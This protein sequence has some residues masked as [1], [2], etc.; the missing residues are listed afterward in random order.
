MRKSFFEEN[1]IL[2]LRKCS[3]H[4]PLDL[5]MATIVNQPSHRIDE[6]HPQLIWLLLQEKCWKDEYLSVTDKTTFLQNTS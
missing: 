1:E 3:I 5:E 4:C 6:R 2:L